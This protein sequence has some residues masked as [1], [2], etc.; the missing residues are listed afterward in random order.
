MR[1]EEIE[2]LH[3]F[4]YPALYKQ[5]YADGMLN[6]GAFGPEW[7][8][9]VLPTLKEH[10]P[11]LLYANDLELLNT[12]MVADYMEEGML[13]ADPIHKFVPIATSGAGDWFALYYNLQDGEDVPVVMVW[14]D[15]NEACIL[16]K[17]LQDFIFLQMLEA[18]TDMSTTYPGLLTIGDFADNCQKWLQSHAPYLTERQQAIVKSTFE[19][20]ALTSAELRDI[21]EAEI[22]FQWMDSSFPYQEEI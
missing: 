1:P 12:S 8:K 22:N 20:G 19:K 17:N 3:N 21:L 4:R 10:P 5:L 13:F 2:Q 7:Y 16:A 11:L 14:H 9:Q 15:A 18:V 6:W